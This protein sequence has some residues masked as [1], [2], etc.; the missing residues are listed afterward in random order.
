MCHCRKKRRIAHWLGLG[1]VFVSEQGTSH[2]LAAQGYTQ[3]FLGHGEVSLLVAEC[4]ARLKSSLVWS[5]GIQSGHWFGV[6]RG[7]IRTECYPKDSYPPLRPHP[8]SLTAFQQLPLTESEKGAILGENA[9]I[10]A[11]FR[12]WL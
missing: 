5:R 10:F 8:R 12:D 1:L 6:G 3:L 11:H 7:G 2:H 9:L 4:P